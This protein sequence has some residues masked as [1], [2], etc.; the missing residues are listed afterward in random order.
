VTELPR[1]H[2]CVSWHDISYYRCGY[3]FYRPCWYRGII[4]YRLVV[5][6]IGW[7]YYELPSSAITYTYNYNT[8]YYYDGTYYQPSEQDGHDGY[9]VV[10]APAPAENPDVAD[11]ADPINLL[12]N[13]SDYL[14]AQRHFTL[15]LT[16]TY[17]EVDESGEGSQISGVRTIYVQRPGKWAADSVSEQNHQ[18][19]TYDGKTFTILD[20]TQNLYSRLTMDGTVDE[21][22][23]TLADEYGI[24]LPMQDI[25]YKDIF[26]RLSGSIT[27]SRYL[28]EET[29]AGDKC[30][31]LAFTGKDADFEIWIK[32][33][34]APIPR[35]IVVN[36]KNTPGTARYTM[37]VTKWDTGSIS[38]STFKLELPKGASK[39]DL[40]PVD[41][42]QPADTEN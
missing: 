25:L 26:E 30:D 29:V 12:E 28:G 34:D 23:Q 15:T 5:V 22:M 8:Y 13:M 16:D 37:I 31:H 42:Q 10:Q 20:V 6:P 17:E 1:D 9:V 18:R 24:S 3:H 33:G 21:T 40:A 4:C 39:I 38:D 41:K 14:S 19:I 7:F 11:L 36:Y 32:Q 35:M 2:E 27:S